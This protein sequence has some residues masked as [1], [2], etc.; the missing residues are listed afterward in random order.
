VGLGA[1]NWGLVGLANFD[2]IKLTF[3]RSAASRAVYSVVGA[4][5]VYTLLRR[6]QLSR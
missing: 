1:L 2:A 5:G 4:A 3:G 6:R